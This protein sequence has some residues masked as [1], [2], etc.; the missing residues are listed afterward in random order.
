MKH[1]NKGLSLGIKIL[2]TLFRWLSGCVHMYMYIINN[3]VLGEFKD[4][5]MRSYSEDMYILCMKFN[6]EFTISLYKPHKLLSFT[7]NRG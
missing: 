3:I 4:E 7:F 1:D 6:F 2:T 5:S